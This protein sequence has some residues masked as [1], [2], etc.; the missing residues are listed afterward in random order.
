MH[1][2]GYGRKLSWFDRGIIEEFD[3]GTEETTRTSAGIPVEFR[4]EHFQNITR[5]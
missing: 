1:W 5:K 2:K 4:N 3:W